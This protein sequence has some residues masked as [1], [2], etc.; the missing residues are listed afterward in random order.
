[1]TQD[2]LLARPARWVAASQTL[3][4]GLRRVIWRHEQRFSRGSLEHTCPLGARA[5][6]LL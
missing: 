4:S 6:G 1:V 2:S 3:T 5:W